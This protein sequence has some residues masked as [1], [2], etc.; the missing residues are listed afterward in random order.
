MRTTAVGQ[1]E[2]QQADAEVSLISATSPPA[3]RPGRSL[4]AWTGDIA[5][6]SAMTVH[7]REPTAQ[8]TVIADGRSARAHAISRTDY[9]TATF[10][11]PP[12]AYA[13]RPGPRVSSQS[14]SA[15]GDRISPFTTDPLRSESQEIRFV[16]R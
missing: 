6:P 5:P 14:S 10:G 7:H 1:T 4:I 9:V 8:P 3:Q 2:L 16:F 11:T 12:N 15:C 13:G